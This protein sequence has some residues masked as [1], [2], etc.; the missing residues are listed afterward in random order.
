V[1]VYDGASTRLLLLDPTGRDPRVM[2]S[3][4]YIQRSGDISFGQRA[5]DFYLEQNTGR[6][7]QYEMRRVGQIEMVF[8]EVGTLVK[9][10]YA[11]IDAN[12]PGRLFQSLKRFLTTR[13][14]IGASKPTTPFVQEA[15]SA[16]SF[17]VTNV[18]GMDFRLEELLSLLAREIV[19]LTEAA[20]GEPVSRLTVGWPVR[21]SDE[22][23]AEALARDRLRE[24]WRLASPAEIEFV[25]E[26]I[27]AIQ[28][29]AH[30][31]E[32][33]NRE[34]AL[35]FDFGGGTLDVCVARIEG[36]RAE[37]LATRGV[38]IGGDLLDSRIVEARLAPLF[39]EFAVYKRN[40][41]PLPR[42]LFTRLRTWQTLSELNKPEYVRLI[43]R[44]KFECDQPERIEM[45]ETLVRRNY[46][47]AFFQAVERAKVQLSD[48]LEA[49]VAL[50][51]PGLSLAHSLS[52]PEF[53]SAVS[54][55][56]NAA[57]ACAEE[58]LTAAGL[59]PD[60]ID[61]VVT[62][63]GSSLIPVFQ[64]MLRETFP[65]AAFEASDAFTSVAAGLAVHGA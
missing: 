55:Q 58:A 20:L 26:P 9:D 56:V 48:R 24:A 60:E 21:F 47:L 3:L 16:T 1:A 23:E 37:A 34:H 28:H 27:A 63:G 52:R 33:R 53:E 44:A 30:R 39:G 18:F 64:R 29:F 35:V 2:R 65:R 61:L 46:G 11:L 8:A 25:E 13:I 49:E 36:G 59:A 42:H 57:R 41:L 62:T 54:A 22:P 6:R 31:A 12:E 38:P 15:A 32:L 51:M 19:R 14:G 5:L 45:L 4:I 17:Q 40:G 43:E 50:D 10:A 7:V